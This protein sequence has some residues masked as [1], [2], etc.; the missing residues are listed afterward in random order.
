MSREIPCT[1]GRRHAIAGVR[2]RLRQPS[3]AICSVPHVAVAR[4]SGVS[5]L[6]PP[7]C[8]NIPPA[9]TDRRVITRHRRRHRTHVHRHEQYSIYYAA[10]LTAVC[11]DGVTVVTSASTTHTADAVR[12]NTTYARQS[13]SLIF[14]QNHNSVDRGSCRRAVA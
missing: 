9:N 6:R 7:S 2:D 1:G 10:R 11:D 5:S 14:L 12:Q 8:A 4:S 3:A 13:V